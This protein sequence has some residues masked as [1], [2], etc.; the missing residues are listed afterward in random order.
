MKKL[1]FSIMISV[2]ACVAVF[3]QKQK[4]VPFN[5]VVADLLGQPL[6]GA[7]VWVVDPNY[8]T[9]T[10]KK[11]KFGLTNVQPTDTLHI[12][13]KKQLYL[14]PVDTMKSVRVRL[15]DELKFDVQQDE[16]LVNTGFGFVKR[17]ESCNSSTGISGDVLVRTGR[18]DVLEALQGLVPG[19]SIVNGKAVI[20][21][22]ATI[23]GSPDP[24][25]LVDGVEVESLSFV[26]VYV[27]DRVEVLKDA[28]MYGVKGANG[29]ILVT[30][31][32]GG[33]KR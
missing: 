3:A 28:N 30:T 8:Y 15:G 24:L 9:T 16:E 11:G 27:V 1:I 25:F 19:L 26:N 6:K 29:A 32:R 21:G 31:K 10:D 22:L 20:R 13:Y 33:S 5:G 23:N 2:F 17:R 4:A 7:R 12:K 18:T 14:I